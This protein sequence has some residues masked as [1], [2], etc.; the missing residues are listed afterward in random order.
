MTEVVRFSWLSSGQGTRAPETT[1]DYSL[2]KCWYGDL[3]PLA[4]GLE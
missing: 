2:A 3:L 1:T 4:L